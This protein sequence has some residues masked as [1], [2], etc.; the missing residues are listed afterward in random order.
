MLGPIYDLPHASETSLKSTHMCCHA[1]WLNLAGD[2][3]SFRTTVCS[4]LILFWSQEEL[5]ALLLL[6]PPATSPEGC[7][8]LRSC[9]AGAARALQPQHE[10]PVSSGAGGATVL[11]LARPAVQGLQAA[12]EAFKESWSEH[13]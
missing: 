3:F 8:T 10:P 1:T 4:K 7:V 13:H 2:E 5:W 6:P 9:S 11:S 12:G